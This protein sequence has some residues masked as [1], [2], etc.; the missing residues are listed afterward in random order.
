MLPDGEPL[1]RLKTPLY[2][3]AE[4]ARILRAKPSTFQRWT[5]GYVTA[6][7]RPMPPL[8]SGVRG[9]RGYSVPFLSL[10]EAYVV[11]T[12][13]DAGVTMPHIR[14]TVTALRDSLGIEYALASR[15]MKT[16]G[17]VILWEHEQDRGD[18]SG[19]VVFANGQAVF[20]DVVAD[21]LQTIT[22]GNRYAE[23]IEMAVGGAAHIDIHP[24]RNFGQPTLTGTGVRVSDI[25][26]RLRAGESAGSVAADY[27]V[28]EGAVRSLL[29]L[30]A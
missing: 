22:Y 10:A 16:D 24:L 13:L 8:V 7:G 21:R 9:G 14:D 28:P 27:E 2:S 3:Q 20:R 11:R 12:L 6:H 4:V 30:A 5:R 26:N 29:S 18:E 19:L 17:A 1:D 25:V 15:R 23:Q